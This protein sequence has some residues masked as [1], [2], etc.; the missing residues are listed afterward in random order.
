M[1]CRFAALCRFAFAGSFLAKRFECSE[2]VEYHACKLCMHLQTVFANVIHD[3]QRGKLLC[4]NY[5]HSDCKSCLKSSPS[6]VVHFVFCL[7]YIVFGMLCF[8][9]QSIPLASSG[10]AAK[11]PPMRSR[12]GRRF[13]GPTASQAP[14]GGGHWRHR[15]ATQSSGFTQSAGVERW[16][17]LQANKHPSAGAQWSSAHENL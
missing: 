3:L 10:L 8:L 16:A 5:L 2:T 11:P 14:A 15:P 13:P 1:L 9:R 12:R 7:L 4:K 17:S 6:T